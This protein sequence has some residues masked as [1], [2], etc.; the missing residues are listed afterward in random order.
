MYAICKVETLEEEF[1]Q[2]LP[3]CNVKTADAGF[4]KL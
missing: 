2:V 1:P 3:S 4:G